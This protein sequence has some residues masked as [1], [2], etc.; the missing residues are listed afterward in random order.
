[1]LHTSEIRWFIAGILSKEAL[2]WFS[3]GHRLEQ[4]TVQVHE[5]L[6]FPGCDAVGVKFR[7]DRFEIKANLGVS[8]PLS[9]PVSIQ[10]RSE[11]WI[12]WS[13]P[14]K[15]LPMLGRTLHQ[16]GPWLK[17]HKE[18]NQRTFSAETG[19]LQEVSRDSLPVTGCNIELT[20]VEVEADS[21][22]W[23]TLGF[24]AYGPPSVTPG[25]LE[26]GVGSFFK[27][28]GQAPGMNL[29]QTNSFSYPA[30]LMNLRMK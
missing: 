16:S 18:R 19:H 2:S 24:E 25:I 1:M 3:A 27:A 7:E 28:Q 20:S 11:R 14:T 15:G 4:A 21:Q 13:L 8:Q 9:L 12:K 6:L 10:G 26:E 30:W 17:V 29:T 5:Y 23:F 22:S